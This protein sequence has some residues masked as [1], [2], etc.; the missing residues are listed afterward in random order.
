MHILI[1]FLITVSLISGFR[2]VKTPPEKETCI[3]AGYDGGILPQ[4]AVPMEI[5]TFVTPVSKLEFRNVTKQHFD[6]SC[7]SAALA[8]L[9]N[10]VLGEHFTEEQVIHGLFEYGDKERVKEKRAF[11]LLD[12]KRFVNVLGYTGVGYRAD[13]ED[14]KP[15]GEL[16][17]PSI[18]PIDLFGYRHFT[19]FKG[20][21][22]GHVF[23]ADPYRGNSSYTIQEFQ[24]MWHKNVVFVVY[25]KSKT[26]ASITMLSDNDLRFIDEDAKFDL[27]INDMPTMVERRPPEPFPEAIQYYKR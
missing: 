21:Y 19:V 18:I 11:S 6:Y 17:M 5:H 9:L 13:I 25:P 10:H 2:P 24:K 27:I 22:K 15:G 16:N 1:A 8:T 14:L 3:Y 20:I 12:M 4:A 7:G 23:L 26:P